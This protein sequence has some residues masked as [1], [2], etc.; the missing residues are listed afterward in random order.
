MGA[1]VEVKTPIERHAAM[2][3]AQRLKRV[4]KFASEFCGR[5]SGSVKVIACI[6]DQDIIDRILSHL[7]DK[8]PPVPS[9]PLL[10]PPS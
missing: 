5:S 7:S 6:G 4:F 3:L 8:E 2:T 10:T 9:L 1:R